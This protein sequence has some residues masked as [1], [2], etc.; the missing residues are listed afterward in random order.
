MCVLEKDDW[1]MNLKRWGM[2]VYGLEWVRKTTSRF[3][4]RDSISEIPKSEAG[5]ITAYPS[6]LIARFLLHTMYHI[7]WTQFHTLRLISEGK[8][9]L[10]AVY[11]NCFWVN[12]EIIMSLVF[13]FALTWHWTFSC[14]EGHKRSECIPLYLQRR[15]AGRLEDT[16]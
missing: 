2:K 15:N 1:M 11:R 8:S 6:C 3:R 4:N 9:S 16:T 14:D 10:L 5:I 7:N 13:A 12:D